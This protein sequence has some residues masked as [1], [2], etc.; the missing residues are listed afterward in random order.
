MKALAHS[1][2]FGSLHFFE[3][4][5]PPLLF[6]TNVLFMLSGYSVAIG[7]QQESSSYSDSG[8]SHVSH[9]KQSGHS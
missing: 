4:V 7:F 3:G 2:N 8:R 5:I 6:L 1:L 9:I